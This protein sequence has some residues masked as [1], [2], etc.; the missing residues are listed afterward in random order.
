[1]SIFSPTMSECEQESD[2]SVRGH[3][4]S[5]DCDEESSGL[6]NVTLDETNSVQDKLAVSGRPSKDMTVEESVEERKF[7]FRYV[8]VV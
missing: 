5:T 4:S 2:S 1:M 3:N 8:L 7:H 6:D